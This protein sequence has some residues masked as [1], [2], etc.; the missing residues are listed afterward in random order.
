MKTKGKGYIKTAQKIAHSPFKNLNLGCPCNIF[1]QMG[2]EPLFSPVVLYSWKT[3]HVLVSG[4]VA[5]N[6]AVR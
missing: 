5:M 6:V 1:L 2:G 4:V 3:N